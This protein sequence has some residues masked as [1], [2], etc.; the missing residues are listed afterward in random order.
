MSK[1]EKGRGQVVIRAADAATEADLRDVLEQSG[2]SVS[3][4]P[5]DEVT[6]SGCDA[7]AHIST[8][9][10]FDGK[11]AAS[12]IPEC[13]LGRLFVSWPTLK[14]TMQGWLEGEEA[15]IAFF[16]LNL[17]HFKRV[18]AFLGD[19]TAVKI[20]REVAARLAYTVREHVGEGSC[21]EG[22]TKVLLSHLT[23]DEFAIS[24]NGLCDRMTAASLA[25]A[26]LLAIS[27][28]Y[29]GVAPQVY[30][31]ARIGIAIAPD[32]GATSDE[33]FRNVS[34]IV[35]HEQRQGRNSYRF[36]AEGM[37]TSA[38]KR[39][40]LEGALGQATVGEEIEIYYQPQA[41]LKDGRIHGAEALVRWRHRGTMLPADIFIATAEDV[42]LITEI[43]NRV[44]L[45]ACHEARRLQDLGFRDMVVSI[46]ISPYQ[47]RR[48][49]IVEVV[50]K[51][52]A[53]TGLDPSS[54]VLEVTESLMLSD[55]ERTVGIFGKLRDMGIHLA[56][57]DF[58]TGY[59][60][61]SYLKS[62]TIDRLKIDRSFVE[63]LPNSPGD[64]AVTEAIVRMARALDL[65][66]TAEGVET[67][68]QRD[69]LKGLGCDH[70]QGFLLSKPLPPREF[71]RFLIEQSLLPHASS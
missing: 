3:I 66:V 1:P 17:D 32:D 64:R 8:T 12:I 54:L 36:Y 47:F 33:L 26:L 38:E 19:E 9:L 31:T 5:V 42:G 58:G 61:L 57:D 37:A 43:G 16:L 24:V 13:E 51:A 52:L 70:Y 60:S 25:R 34:S 44:L 39:F 28:P 46:N 56:L 21:D 62:L 18:R 29:E 45:G 65:E 35:H 63:E 71:E 15:G 68:A 7:L 69:F 55:V 20:L 11:R 23:G 10:Q 22:G 49:G 50:Q 59:S 30:L 27:Q 2:Y 40:E 6:S 14:E 53:T 41:D 48:L 4:E 67:E